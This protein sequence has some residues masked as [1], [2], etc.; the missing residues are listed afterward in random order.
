MPYNVL[1]PRQINRA[2]R[3][4]SDL[5]AHD[6]LALDIA[7]CH[8]RIVTVVYRVDAA[9]SGGGKIVESGALAAALAHEVAREQGLPAD[10]LEEDVKFHLA[11]TAARNQPQLQSYAPGL[12]L[13]L[14]EPDHLLALKLHA[15]RPGAAPAPSDRLDVSFLLERTGLASP[16]AAERAYRRFFPEQSLGET[17]RA[18]LA[19]VFPRAHA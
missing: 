4:L 15:L 19:R 5:A 16:E 14:G 8:G 17:A 7:L 18:F 11:L 10:W 13:S 6:G 12:V 2:L 3:R 9:E 1:S